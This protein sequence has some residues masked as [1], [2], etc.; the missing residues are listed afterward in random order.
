M[1]IASTFAALAAGAVLFG[2]VAPANAQTAT[3]SSQGLTSVDKNLAKDK[4]GDSDNKGLLT[5][6]QRIER[7]QKRHAL[8]EEE[9]AERKADRPDRPL[10]PEHPERP[11]R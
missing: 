1:R 9:L 3:P 8:H 7:N 2:T 4:D 10:R 5:A 11:G 6:Q